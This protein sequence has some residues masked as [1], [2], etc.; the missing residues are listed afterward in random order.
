MKSLADTDEIKSRLDIVEIVSE[1]V[2]LQRA[3]RNYKANCPF[4]NEKTP[5]FIVD[6]SRQSWRCFGQCA[7]GGDVF[8]FIMKIDGLEFGDALRMLAQRAGVEITFKENTANRDDFFAINEV[9]LKFYKEALLSDE[10]IPARDY[11]DQRG[12]GDDIRQKFAIGYSPK[13]K[14]SLKAH[15][16]FHD[17]DLDKAVE[18]GLLNRTEHGTTRDFFWGR[19]MFPIH[20]RTG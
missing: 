2:Q 16:A 11:L 6:P 4:H 13:G 9:A 8:S 15:L 5:S 17:I 20:D 1:R 18:C 3:G 7:S 14:S 12:L 19:L 10:G